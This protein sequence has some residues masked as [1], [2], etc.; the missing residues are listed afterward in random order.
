MM[1]RYTPY[2]WLWMLPVMLVFWGLVIA[3]VV[4]VVRSLAHPH[5][6]DDGALEILRR[7][8]AAGEITAEEFEKMR[9]LLQP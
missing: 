7:R 9:K 8:L 4:A 6:R 3:L 1:W 2:V 5:G